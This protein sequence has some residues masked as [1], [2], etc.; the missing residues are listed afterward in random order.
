LPQKGFG[1]PT[2]IDVRTIMKNKL[3]LDSPRDERAGGKG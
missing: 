1:M 2:T 3:P